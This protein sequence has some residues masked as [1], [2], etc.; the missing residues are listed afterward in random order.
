M[1]MLSIINTQINV[2]KIESGILWGGI[3]GL[4]TLPIYYY[5]DNCLIP[6]IS[7]EFVFKEIASNE[8]LKFLLRMSFFIGFLYGYNTQRRLSN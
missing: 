6:K 2:K 7:D 3:F 4:S 8:A 5:I 1:S